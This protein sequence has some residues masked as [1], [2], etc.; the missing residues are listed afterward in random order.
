MCYLKQRHF[1]HPTAASETLIHLAAITVHAS[2]CDR[3]PVCNNASGIGLNMA[4]WSL[5]DHT[6]QPQPLSSDYKLQRWLWIM[7]KDVLARLGGCAAE[8]AHISKC[9]TLSM[10]TQTN[11]QR[12]AN[13]LGSDLSITINDMP[14]LF[15]RFSTP[16]HKGLLN[17]ALSSLV[18]VQKR[19][20]KIIF[21]TE[22]FLE[23]LR[24]FFHK[25]CCS[26]WCILLLKISILVMFL[27]FLT[28]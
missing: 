16:I 22:S 12:W 23:D 14:K 10:Y 20:W 28:D 13:S 4:A 6:S 8:C 11:R 27:W 2:L 3:V 21:R 24:V 15:G 7:I 19:I 18:N 25:C 5:G 9:W 26:L 1:W 17:A